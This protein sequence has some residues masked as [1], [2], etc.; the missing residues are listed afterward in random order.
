MNL[1]GSSR[2]TWLVRRGVRLPGDGLV[3]GANL[4]ARVA[5]GPAAETVGAHAT[6]LQG[7]ARLTDD[8]NQ[9]A[10]GC[11]FI[12][13]TPPNGTFSLDDA[14][15]VHDAVYPDVGR[16]GGLGL[17]GWGLLVACW[18]LTEHCVQQIPDAWVLT[19]CAVFEPVV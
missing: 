13:V 16:V 8:L 14:A 4:L 11:E 10:L 6:D 5:R 15:L 19:S 9:Q 3:E 17:G 2:R 12:Q 7:F 1:H 18:V